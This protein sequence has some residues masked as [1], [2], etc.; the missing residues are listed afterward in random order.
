M[1]NINMKEIVGDT[2]EDM[3]I[4]EMTM[5]QGSGDVNAE[6]T[7]ELFISVTLA[8]TAAAGSYAS[9]VQVVKTIKGKC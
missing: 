7:I 4:A 5:I 1:A 8:A 3:S 9:G 2:F 6:T